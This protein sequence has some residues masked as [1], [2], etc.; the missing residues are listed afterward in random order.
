MVVNL[1]G[2]DMPLNLRFV[3]GLTERKRSSGSGFIASSEG[4]HEIGPPPFEI[5][6][7]PPIVLRFGIFGYGN[8]LKKSVCVA[9]VLLCIGFVPS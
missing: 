8:W 2:R 6:V 1:R 4:L 3:G 5:M 7:G 9:F